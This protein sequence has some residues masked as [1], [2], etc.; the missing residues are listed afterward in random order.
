MS[1]DLEDAVPEMGYCR[2]MRKYGECGGV[3]QR[4]IRKMYKTNQD[5]SK[6]RR[7]YVG[8]RCM[9]SDCRTWRSAKHFQ[10]P[11]SDPLL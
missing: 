8:Y 1:L 9:R 5:G 6:I 10:N 7:S 11:S 4:K 2:R 3:F